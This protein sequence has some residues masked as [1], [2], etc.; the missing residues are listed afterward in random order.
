MLEYPILFWIQDLITP[1]SSIYSKI[2]CKY[3]ELSSNVFCNYLSGDAKPPGGGITIFDFI[4]RRFISLSG[5]Q[6]VM[7]LIICF[8]GREL[9]TAST[10]TS[11]VCN[12]SSVRLLPWVFN[13]ELRT[14]IALWIC[15]SQTLPMLPANGGFLFQLIHS[16][17]CSSK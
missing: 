4:V 7:P 9:A 8:N 14:I 3:A 2:H 1:L 13:N 11:W 5:I 12:D 6:L 16:P 17:P 15:H 10:S